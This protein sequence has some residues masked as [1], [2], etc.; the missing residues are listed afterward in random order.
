MW[1]LDL[2]IQRLSAL[3]V[4]GNQLAAHD[5]DNVTVSARGGVVLC[6]D[7]GE[8]ADEYGPG[9]RARADP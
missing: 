6:E 1:V 9:A 2:F 3:F 5:P 7:G 8:S 4:S